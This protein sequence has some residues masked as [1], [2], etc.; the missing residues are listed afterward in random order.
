MEATHQ[1]GK[2]FLHHTVENVILVLDVTAC[3]LYGR[4]ISNFGKEQSNVE[5]GRRSKKNKHGSTL[6]KLSQSLKNY[7]PSV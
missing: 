1:G 5:A 7:V 6:Q 3:A 2:I 4:Q